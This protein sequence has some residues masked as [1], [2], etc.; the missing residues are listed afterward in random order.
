MTHGAFAS[1]L[2][3][4]FFFFKAGQLFIR[5]DVKK[6]IFIGFILFSGANAEMVITVTER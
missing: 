4:I 1:K 3:K 2:H 5:Y 6:L